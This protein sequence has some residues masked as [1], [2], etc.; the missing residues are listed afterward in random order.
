MDEAYQTYSH[1]RN[2][3]SRIR[4]FVYRGHRCLSIENELLRVVV[5]ADK[6]ADILEFL[7]KPIDLEFLWRSYGGLR[8]VEHFRPSSPLTAGHF[9]EHYAG[10]WHEMLPNGAGPCEHRGA[11]FGFHGEATNLAWDYTIEIDEVEC[12]EVKFR[13]RLVRLPLLV[14]KTLRL[15]SGQSSLRIR[16]RI[17]NEAGHAVEMLWGHHPTFGWPFLE[18]GCKVNLPP[19]RIVVGDQPLRGSRLAPSQSSNWP[20]AISSGG[21]PLDLSL[22]PGP[23]ARSQDFVRLE[24][25]EEGWFSIV[26]PHRQVGFKL[27]WDKKIFP[28]LGFWQVFRG[29]EDYPWYGMTYL[30]ALE[31]A[32][33]LPSLTDAAERGTALK[34]ESG[35]ALETELVAT[36]FTSPHVVP[37]DN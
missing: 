19:C 34:L 2:Y 21:D 33:D 5:S 32:C 27:T 9:R 18:A 1:E 8:Q 30:A 35:V 23:E 31:P 20:I 24:G 15:E 37:G 12:V 36:A 28:M 10:G 22:I 14:E 3:G 25:L 4:E 11:E 16:E 29:A 13:V 26:N 17:V 6:G 7:Y